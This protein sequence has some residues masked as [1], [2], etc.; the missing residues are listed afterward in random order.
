MHGLIR[1][2]TEVRS[3]VAAA[4]WLLLPSLAHAHSFGKLYNLPVPFWLYAYGAAASLVVSFLIVG[5]FVTAPAPVAASGQGIDLSQRRWVMAV[6]RLRLMTVLRAVS[7]GCLLLC[8]A[9]GFFGH[10]NPYT[11]FSMT[12]FWI[13]F[14][15]GFAYLTALLGD[16]YA[17]LNPWRVLGDWLARLWPGYA[18]GQ[19]GYPPSLGY[20]PALALYMGLIW[21]E[22][23][24]YIRPHSLAWLLTGYSLLNLLGVWLIGARDWFRY[25]EFTG[26]F[27]R[28]IALLAP[29]DT[30]PGRLRLRAPFA[31]VL[32]TR[33]EHTSLLLFVLF[34][35]SSTAFDGLRA[36]IPWMKLFWHDTL[37]V[38]RPW[39]GEMPITRYGDLRWLYDA[40]E[41]FCLLLSPLLYWLVYVFFIALAKLVT[42]SPLSVHA[43]SLRFAFS[44]LPIALVYNIT[45]Y[46]T[47]IL[48]QGVKIVSLVSDPFGYGWDLFGTAGKLGAPILPSMTFIWHS[49][50]GLI[51]FGHIVSVWL[52]H[53][54]A[55]RTFPG[56]W[57]AIA[58]Q[59][60]MLV[61]MVLFTT[62][63]LW[64]L[65][66]PLQGGR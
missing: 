53:R 60:P 39:V 28:L 31:G 15:L 55:L 30:V 29:I 33:A 8:I 59:L 36:T 50:V 12:F 3:L 14:L 9:T 13:V 35:L 65:S 37:G 18:Q 40:W 61:L 22:L 19:W 57:Q 23:F 25:C 7:V 62:A 11:N 46:Y 49:Q 63:G 38:L 51:L 47:L 43:L 66:Q 6:R 26:V 16:W 56:R 10:R 52:A 21:A 34:M 48:T 2:R 4:L 32:Q 24:L 44:L 5:F 45:H 20:W 42:L 27:F 64:I 54:E 1:T 41:A 17:A 58:S